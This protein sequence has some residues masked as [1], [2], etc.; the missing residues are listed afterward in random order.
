MNPF[1]PTNPVHERDGVWYYWDETWANEIGP[2]VTETIARAELARYVKTE[3]KTKSQA[4]EWAEDS[5]RWRHGEVLTGFWAHWCYD[6]DGLPVDETTPSEFECC[7]C[8]EDVPRLWSWSGIRWRLAQRVWQL[9]ILFERGRN[10]L[11]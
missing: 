10:R 1:W 5:R 6:W 4:Q 2:F 9:Q 11:R 8:F 7:H 3:L